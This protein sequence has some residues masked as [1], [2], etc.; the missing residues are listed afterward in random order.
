M[1]WNTDRGYGTIDM[2]SLVKRLLKDKY[3]ERVEVWEFRDK[4][5]SPKYEDQNINPYTKVK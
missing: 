5:T 4:A 2:A 1:E 3:R